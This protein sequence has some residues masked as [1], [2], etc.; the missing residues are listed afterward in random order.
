MTVT[1]AKVLLVLLAQPSYVRDRDESPAAREELLRPVAEA[2]ATTARNDTEAA[3]LIADGFH[4]SGYSRAV[5]EYRCR[6]L[7]R[8]ACDSGKARGGWQVHS[9]CKATDVVG[10]AR[11]VLRV[12]R[13]GSGLCR[14]HALNPTAGAFAALAA[15]SCNWSGAEVR[16]RTYRKILAQLRRSP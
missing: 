13:Y 12:A 5:L 4:E 7:G 3:V 14:E 15:R 8:L 10:E 6:D 9:W 1:A 16:V 2:I 11:C